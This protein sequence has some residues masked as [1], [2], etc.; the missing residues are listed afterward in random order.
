M[1]GHSGIAGVIEIPSTFMKSF[2]FQ[3]GS[4]L[5]MHRFRQKSSDSARKARRGIA[6]VRKRRGSICLAWHVTA[7][8][9]DEI[10]RQRVRA[11]LG[12]LD[13]GTKMRSR[14]ND[15]DDHSNQ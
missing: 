1:L 5:E 14:W 4:K 13:G 7:M 3:E 6:D 2:Q 10:V 8:R 12:T 11:R 15:G 9:S